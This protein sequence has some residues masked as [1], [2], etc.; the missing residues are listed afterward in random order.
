MAMMTLLAAVMLFDCSK[1]ITVI[2][3]IQ[4]F[5]P[6]IQKKKKKVYLTLTYM[7]L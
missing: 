3:K 1:S 6:E 4:N 2:A 7:F 5:G